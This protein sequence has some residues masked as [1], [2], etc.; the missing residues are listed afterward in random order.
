MAPKQ[1]SFLL[2]T[3]KWHGC[4]MQN[5]NT[6]Q[7]KGM[8]ISSSEPTNLGLLEF[9]PNRNSQS[10]NAP[11]Y[12]LDHSPSHSGAI[13]QHNLGIMT[14]GQG[15]FTSMLSERDYPVRLEGSNPQRSPTGQMLNQSARYSGQG[16][17]TRQS[18]PYGRQ[19]VGHLQQAR[20]DERMSMLIAA[21][22]NADHH[23][24]SMLIQQRNRESPERHLVNSHYEKRSMLPGIQP[25][26][27]SSHDR[28]LQPLSDGKT[29][30]DAY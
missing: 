1:E 12:I 2:V 30:L 15:G 4:G 10:Q 9:A 5:T 22:T 23:R 25:G 28:L 19:P 27:L 29:N 16:D 24:I 18:M 21:N 17:L 13:G 3:W 7:Q 6:P 11:H 26:Y 14:A 8:R 20:D